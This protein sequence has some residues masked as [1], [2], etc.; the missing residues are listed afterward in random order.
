M[1]AK[2]RTLCMHMHATWSMI[3]KLL[4]V[5]TPLKSINNFSKKIST[6][7]I[8]LVTPK[9]VLILIMGLHNTSVALYRDCFSTPPFSVVHP[10]KYL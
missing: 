9:F 5:S 3:I 4:H 2:F 7:G 8:V 1:H 10:Y 6:K